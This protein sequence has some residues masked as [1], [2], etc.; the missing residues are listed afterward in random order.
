MSNLITHGIQKIYPEIEREM[1]Y[2]MEVNK[3]CNFIVEQKVIPITTP[4]PSLGYWSGVYIPSH[5]NIYFIP[6]T[7]KSAIKWHY[8]STI[9]DKMYEYTPKIASGD[10]P[11][12][13]FYNG[14]YDYKFNRII[15]IPYQTA[16]SKVSVI[17]TSTI[18]PRTMTQ[19][20][21]AGISQLVC[22]G[23]LDSSTSR[24]YLLN[25]STT[26]MLYYLDISQKVI[27]SGYITIPSTVFNY[28]KG[29][30]IDKNGWLYDI[31]NMASSYTR[32]NLNN[33]VN[34]TL[35]VTDIQT[36]NATIGGTT[37][38]PVYLP[39]ENK[40][41]SGANSKYYD[42]NS[43]TDVSV[44]TGYSS[45]GISKNLLNG[46]I[47]YKGLYSII[48][49]NNFNPTSTS[50]TL[51]SYS[52]PFYY[53]TI[54]LI[55]DKNGDVYCFGFYNE[56]YTTTIKLAKF[57]MNLKVKPSMDLIMSGLLN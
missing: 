23:V 25:A 12:D 6:W 46:K 10:L 42:L 31:R 11:N 19:T 17:D 13:G 49:R 54:P 41:Y 45:S 39:H 28:S 16:M 21:S 1:Q 5:N 38:S 27:T 7:Q 4:I 22:Y 8:Y 37:Y 24:I 52:Y 32:F 20:L 50:N 30:F 18:P 33:I 57:Q 26:T 51:S 53:Q 35:S 2:L 36:F 9:E 55:T 14:I 3:D 48:I 29:G 34:N 47:I 15:L 56:S 44:T 40:I 43:M